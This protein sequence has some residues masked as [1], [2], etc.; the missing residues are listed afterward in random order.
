MALVIATLVLLTSVAGVLY[1]RRARKQAEVASRKYLASIAHELSQP[2][3]A[4]LHNAEL[5]EKLLDRGALDELEGVL[6]DIRSEDLRAA[7]IIRRQRTMLQREA[8][9][10][11][12]VDVNALVRDS[13]ARVARDAHLRN[14]RIETDLGLSLSPVAGDEVLL[15][16]MFLN[17]V[18]NGMD[19][20]ARTPVSR[21]RL[22]VRTARVDDRIEIAVHDSGEGIAPEVATHLF[23]PFVTTKA[24]GMGMGLSVVQGIVASHGGAIEARNNAEGGATFRVTLPCRAA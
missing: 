1:E 21:R 5:A 13:L 3:S 12:P 2:L 6:R 24:T 23:E 16:Q 14:V 17:L 7:E 8:H 20:M 18:L 10:H 22:S 9:A 11:R 15:Q 19:A 4:I